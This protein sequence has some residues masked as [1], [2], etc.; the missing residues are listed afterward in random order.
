MKDLS[1]QKFEENWKSVF[2]GAEVDPSGSVWSNLE[3]DL[4][5]ME[6]NSMKKKVVFYKWLAAASVFLM[7]F[8]AGAFYYVMQMDDKQSA[9]ITN[10]ANEGSSESGSVPKETDQH[11]SSISGNE[12]SSNGS[13][14]NTKNGEEGNQSE[15]TDVTIITKKDETNNFITENRESAGIDNSLLL[16]SQQI[17]FLNSIKEVPAEVHGKIELPRLVLPAMPAVFMNNSKK[18]SQ[19]EDLWASVGFSA[20]NYNPGNV[21]G[22]T[23][24]RSSSQTSGAYLNSVG[25]SE[26]SDVGSAYSAGFAMSKRVFS[27]WVLQTGV[28]Y[29]N[30]SIGYTS[31]YVS[32]SATNQSKVFV[33]EYADFA[34]SSVTITTPYQINS[35]IEV[36]SLPMQTGYLLIDRKFGWQLN[37]GVAAD[38]FVRNTLTDE[39]GRAQ[40]YSQGSGEESPYRAVSWAG[41]LGTEVSY[42][43]AKQYRV[44]IVP[45]MRYSLN[46]VLKSTSGQA[47]NPLVVDVGFRFRYIFN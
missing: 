28:N 2:D 14:E 5:S 10:S 31:N 4:V 18:N 32:Y 26:P 39:S 9:T 16:K 6:S 46:S 25:Y 34:N 17:S 45:G 33:A 42:K 36:I 41:L 44:S 37:T 13:V 35:A 20:G 8:F 19:T 23:A 47:S 22:T 38:F 43:L 15:K 12:T 3:L 11:T 1:R 27:R 29:I 40:Q 21:S 24:F 7:V 30:Q